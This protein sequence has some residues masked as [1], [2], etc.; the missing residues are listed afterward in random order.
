MTMYV[1][2]ENKNP[3]THNAIVLAA[4]G[5]IFLDKNC[6]G[7]EVVIHQ[8]RSVFISEVHRE[9]DVE[10][11]KEEIEL[12]FT[13]RHLPGRLQAVSAPF[14]ALARFVVENTKPGAEGGCRTPEAPRS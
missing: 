10:A 13:W 12:F 4:D 1:R 14:G 11:R 6:P 3:E 2:I 7:V 9:G 8:E 5:P